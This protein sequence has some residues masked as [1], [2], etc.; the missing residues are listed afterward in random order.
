LLLKPTD[1]HQ[2]FDFSEDS[3]LLVLANQN[4]DPSDYIDLA[5]N[6]ENVFSQII[7]AQFQ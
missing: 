6:P 1:W 2:M 3:I 7:S 4:Y 5:Y